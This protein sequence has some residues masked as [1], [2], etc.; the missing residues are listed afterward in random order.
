MSSYSGLAL[1][2]NTIYV[3]TERSDIVALSRSSGRELWRRKDMRN[4]DIS[5]PAVI[6]SSV[7]VGDFEGYL[8]WYDL[9]TGDLQAR[10]KAGSDRITSQPLVVNDLLFVMN[11][12]GNLFAYSIVPPKQGD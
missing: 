10:V 4:R 5:S 11:D 12:G 8:Q 7:V 6:G 9:S 1:D 3:A 2:I